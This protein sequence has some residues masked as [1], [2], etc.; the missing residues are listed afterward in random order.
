[1]ALAVAAAPAHPQEAPLERAALPAVPYWWPVPLDRSIEAIPLVWYNDVDGT[2]LGAAARHRLGGARVWWGL[3]FGLDGSVSAPAA[4]EFA[5]QIEGGALSARR[6][7]GRHAVTLRSEPLSTGSNLRLSAG[8]AALWIED[9]RYI[10]TVPLFRC[11]A[12][13]PAL[14]CQEI[15]PPYAWSEGRDHAIELD[16]R[17]RPRGGPLRDLRATFAGGLKVFGGDHE[18]LRAEIV[19][20]R[21]AP[22]GPVP[23]TARLAAGW[24]SGNAPRQR[25][26]FL[27]GAGPVTRWLNPGLESRGS[28]FSGLPYFVE[29]GPHLRAYTET[30]PLVNRYIGL[31]TQVERTLRLERGFRVGLGLFLEGAWTPGLPD[32]I[33]PEQMGPNGSILFDWLELPD[34]EGEPRGEFR[35]RVLEVPE[36]WADAGLRVTGGYRRIGVTLSLPFWVNAA[37]FADEPL[38]GDRSPFALRWNLSLTF[39]PGASDRK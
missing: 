9:R 28:L 39:T 21:S 20:R 31:A 2:V 25:R 8:V 3:G 6:L 17:A 1:M 37:D 7:H 33:G 34:G 5:V 26:F 12:E 22:L 38:T 4:A 14:P 19:G 11:S 36:L 24:A 13:A 23:W 35:A 18:Y 15:E 32:R 29:G 27:F 10:E 30:R 16:L